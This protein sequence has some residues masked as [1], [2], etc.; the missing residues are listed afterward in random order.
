[1]ILWEVKTGRVLW[2]MKTKPPSGSAAQPR[3]ART[4]NSK[5][6]KTLTRRSSVCSGVLGRLWTQALS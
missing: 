2:Q 4:G 1:M 6:A 3:A 5:S